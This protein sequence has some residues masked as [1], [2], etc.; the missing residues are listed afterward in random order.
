VAVAVGNSRRGARE[1]DGD[2]A[3]GTRGEAEPVHV[4]VL[5]E[6]VQ[7]PKFAFALVTRALVTGIVTVN[8]PASPE[9]FVTV[10]VYWK[11][12]STVTG[13]A[14]SLS[15]TAMSPT[16]RAVNALEASCSPSG[17]VPAPVTCAVMTPTPGASPCS[18]KVTVAVPFTANVPN[19]QK[20]KSEAVTQ[21]P[22][23]GVMPV[24]V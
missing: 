3:H 24:T 14:D 12:A 1:A 10:A 9:L 21:L 6:R 11:A 5:S 16:G 13:S 22:V 20:K 19:G 8:G 23:L 17:S 2:A 7:P 18:A 4:T 15:V